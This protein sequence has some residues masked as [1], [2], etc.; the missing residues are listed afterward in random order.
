RLAWPALPAG[1]ATTRLAR[2]LRRAVRDGR[3][4]QHLLPAP[5]ARHVR[6][7]AGEDA[8]RFRYDR[9]G[10]PGPPPRQ[11]AA[12]P[13]GTGRQADGRG[14]RAGW[15][16]GP[17]AAPAS[18]E[19][20]RR[21]GA[22]GGLPGGVRQ[23]SRRWPACPGRRWRAGRGGA[24]PSLLVDRGGAAGAHP[25]RRR[26][27]LGRPAAPPRPPPVADGRRGAPP[28]PT[29]AGPSLAPLSL[30]RP[31]PPAWPPGPHP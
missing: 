27:A 14:R 7:L 19:P 4:Q 10:E 8:G 3:E 31:S 13:G 5:G 9:Q 18:A 30:P 17:R 24:T 11:A 22:A 29:G 16:P 1:P 12:G 25:A 21:P 26:A 6:G 15:P 23:V 20:D 2:V 28:P